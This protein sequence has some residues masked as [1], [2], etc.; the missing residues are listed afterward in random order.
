MLKPV[1]TCEFF[2]RSENACKKMK[3]EEVFSVFL[4]LSLLVLYSTYASS[5]FISIE[6]EAKSHFKCNNTSDLWAHVP[7]SSFRW[8]KGRIK[9]YYYRKTNWVSHSF[10]YLFFLPQNDVIIC[11]YDLFFTS[12]TSQNSSFPWTNFFFY[13]HVLAFEVE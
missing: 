6:T 4:I 1:E 9:I 8:V 12:H 7:F 5:I 11:H 2:K 13:I 10:D 3:K